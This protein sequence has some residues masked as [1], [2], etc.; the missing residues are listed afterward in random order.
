VKTQT[1]S[2]TVGDL[3][4]ACRLRRVLGEPDRD[5]ALAEIDG[6]TSQQTHRN[7]RGLDLTAAALTGADLSSLNLRG[8]TLSRA[9]LYGARLDSADLSDASLICPA[10]EKTSLR[11]ATLRGAYLHALAAQACD[12]TQA[13]LSSVLD[14]TGS[15]LHGCQ[16]VEAILDRSS[17][18]GATFYQCDLRGSSW[19]N[20][21]LQGATFNECLL[22][23][24]RFDMA[25]L[26]QVTMTK[27]RLDGVC[28]DGAIGHGLTI[29][30]PTA[31]CR[32]YACCRSEG[33]TGRLA[34]RCFATSTSSTATSR[35]RC[36]RRRTWLGGA[37]C[38][39]IW[40]ER[41]SA[42]RR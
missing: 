26:D 9:T 41:T 24:A 10:M 32:R 36:S 31:R 18:A 30:R 13:D 14:A 39:A 16:L 21:S 7:G 23:G 8:A 33:R 1:E 2:E 20:A 4:D 40:P 25:H 35:A 22:D 5:A 42:T 28:F 15:L 37:S 6:W 34:A 19:K 38:E 3:S 12:F 27:C 17:L 29:Q 11:N